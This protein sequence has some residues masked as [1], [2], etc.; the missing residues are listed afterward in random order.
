MRSRKLRR[1]EGIPAGVI[2]GLRFHRR[3]GLLGFTLM[4]AAAPADTWTLDVERGKVERWTRSEV[5]GLNAS[6]FVSPTLVRYPT[7]DRDA[8]GKPRQIPAFY[9]RPPGKGPH[10]VLIEI[11][12]GPE[13]QW[14]PYFSSLLQYFAVELGV[15]V[16]APNVR[17]SDGYGK[18]YLLLDNGRKREDSVRDI[19]ALLDWIAKRPELDAK[20]V[21]VHGGSY[22]GYM[23]LASLIHYRQ[24]IRAGVDWVG[25]SSFLTFLQN[26]QAY[27]RDLRRAEYGDERDPEM[28]KFLHAISPLTRAREITSPLFVIQGANDPRVP[29]SESTQLVRAVRSSGSPVWFLLAE[30]E[31][32]GFRK[33]A[34]RDLAMMLTALFVENFLLP[35]PASR[36]AP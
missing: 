7:F 24:R 13:G 12:G 33:K 16:L 23:V 18:S 1:P 20:R 2:E 29:A 31:G 10:P 11:H 36:P 21:L 28:R 6:R 26:T 30:N 19:G 8:E 32:H 22:G 27:R 15:A 14:R 4:R 3:R 34:N 25:I 35:A 17:G 9:F 5:G